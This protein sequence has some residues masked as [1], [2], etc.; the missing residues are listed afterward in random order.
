M[1]GI[2]YYSLLWKPKYIYG[3]YGT[4]TELLRCVRSKSLPVQQFLFNEGNRIY[5]YVERH[6]RIVTTQAAVQLAPSAHGQLLTTSF[7]GIN[8]Q[9]KR[10]KR[11]TKTP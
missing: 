10:V 7:R 5:S 2:F 11:L 9:A 8:L 4:Y 3:T 6:P 1:G